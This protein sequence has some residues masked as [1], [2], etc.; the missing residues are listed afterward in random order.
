M[1]YSKIAIAYTDEKVYATH[2][3]LQRGLR[4]SL[5]GDFWKQIEEYR[6]AYQK[7]ILLKTIGG[8]PFYV[9]ETPVLHAKF[10]TFEDKLKTYRSTFEQLGEMKKTSEEIEK[11]FLSENLRLAASLASIRISTPT[12]NALMSGMYDSFGGSDEQAGLLARYRDILKSLPN[13]KNEYSME[14]LARHYGKL[15][16]E[17]E[18]TSFYRESNKTNFKNPTFSIGN[19]IYEEAPF[20]KIEELM[21]AMFTFQHVDACKTL[22]K[23]VAVGFYFLYVKPFDQHNQLLACLA[24]KTLL[25]GKGN[26]YLPLESAFSP[27]SRFQEIFKEIQLSG[28]LTYM[29][30]H[31]ID[32]LSPV[33]DM[34]MDE[35]AKTKLRN[36]EEEKY[37]APVAPQTSVDDIAVSKEQEQGNLFDDDFIEPPLE[38]EDGIEEI[39]SLDALPNVDAKIEFALATQKGGMSEKEIKEAARFLLETHPMLRK[40]Q[41]LFFASHCTI[42]RYY[43][44]QD[45]RKYAK[46]VYETARTSMDN[47]ARERLY[48]KLK[49]KNKYVYTPIRQG[50]SS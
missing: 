37:F 20:E 13:D 35:V 15:S 21:E 10:A 26:A 19:R 31:V 33:M 32:T 43:S 34:M 27:S 29:I 38:K 8:M 18:L 5:I 45:Y 2:G 24:S 3:D 42:G 48:K 1:A 30:L 23:A 40:Q 39:P 36:I 25:G 44:I 12:L 41:A 50:E 6:F 22:F 17:E 47:L 9:V 4:M 11:K 14:D 49:I 16:G 28:D 46:C 7:K